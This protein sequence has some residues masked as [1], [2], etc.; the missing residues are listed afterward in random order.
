MGGCDDFREALSARLDG[1]DEEPVGAAALDAHLA[2][3]RACRRWWDDAVAVNRLVRTGPAVA[4][5]D[6]TEAVLAAAPG[7]RWARLAVALRVALGVLGLAQ[8]VLG[9]YQITM[10]A[11]F[12]DSVLHHPAAEGATL[13]HLWHETAAWNVAVGGG[14]LWIA[15]RR[16]RP[17]G[18]APTLTVFIVALALLSGSDVIAGLVEPLWL[19]SHGFVLAGYLIVLALCR[20]EF[21]LTPP[22]DRA[23]GW[24][25]LRRGSR[26]AQWAAVVP[27]PD[28]NRNQ[29]AAHYPYREAA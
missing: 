20:P 13:G 27:F 5:V 23:G 12:E 26:T 21:D 28:R 1:E 11:G 6:V 17:T 18:V 29:P 14:F 15:S 2:D 24:R 22:G 10:M 19:T 9:V 3:C 4:G 8:L 16:G 7:R 25:L